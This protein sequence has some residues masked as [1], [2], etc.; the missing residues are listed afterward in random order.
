MEDFNVGNY[1]KWRGSFKQP[2]AGVTDEP[3]DSKLSLH[4]DNMRLKDEL[5]ECRIEL[6]SLK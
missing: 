2:S 5:T 1:L 3:A 6:F 4:R